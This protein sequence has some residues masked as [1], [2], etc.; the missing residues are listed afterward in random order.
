[1]QN[2][3]LERH[4]IIVFWHIFEPLR[5]LMILSKLTLTMVWWAN[6]GNFGKNLSIPSNLFLSWRWGMLIGH[7]LSSGGS[8]SYFLL[9]LK[10]RTVS[11][12]KLQN[13]VCYLCRKLMSWK[14]LA[15]DWTLWHSICLRHFA[16]SNTSWEI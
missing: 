10:I 12:K 4:H 1:M 16:N 15:K 14:I 8:L 6:N 9:K 11:F 13:N 5:I 3:R 2:L 7:L